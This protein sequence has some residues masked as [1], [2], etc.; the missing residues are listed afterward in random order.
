MDERRRFERIDIPDSAKL[1]VLDAKGKRLGKL[2]SLGRGGMLFPC[3]VQFASGSKQVFHICDDL[4]GITRAVNVV[5]RYHS[6]EGL[7]C[8]FERLDT[9]AAVDIGVWIGKFYAM[10]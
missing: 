1:W 7:G 3:D 4:E 8:E 10:K 9:D 6:S 5:V 2:K